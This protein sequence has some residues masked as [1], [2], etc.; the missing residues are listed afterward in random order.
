MKSART[1]VTCAMATALF[2]LGLLHG[3]TQTPFSKEREQY[4]RKPS[5]HTSEMKAQVR[6]RRMDLSM[7]S[8]HLVSSLQSKVTVG[9]HLVLS[10]MVH[11]SR[12]GLV[13]SSVVKAPA[14]FLG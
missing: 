12:P 9:V 7:H 2:M 1:S 11:V 3:W 6:A 4:A 13:M 14:R 10:Q 5:A 8:S